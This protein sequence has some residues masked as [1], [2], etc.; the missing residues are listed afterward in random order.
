M[1]SSLVVVKDNK[2]IQ[3]SYKLTLVEQRIILSAI[4]K[5]D[6][7]K[8]LNESQGFTIS[9]SEIHDLFMESKSSAYSEIKK[10]VNRLYRRSI[11][12]DGEGSERRWIYE[13]QYHENKASVTLF[14]SP[15]IIPY[16]TQLKDSFTK[17]KLEYI[18]EFRSSYSIRIYELLVQ[19]TSKGEREIQIEDLKRILDVSDK[20]SR[21]ANFIARV[22][23][24]AIEDINQSS[25]LHVSF[26]T[27]KSG[28]LI[29]HIQFLFGIK[30]EV[31][32]KK[33]IAPIKSTKLTMEQFVRDN[34]KKT[35]G[36]SRDEVIKMMNNKH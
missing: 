1:N 5:I 9:V 14:F 29:T 22:I 13:K 30:A 24:P 35:L 26:G 7:T 33:R 11:I 16:L 15:T 36:K 21:P 18:S 12:L 34:P 25:N 28:R 8:A 10:A 19:W 3:A 23:Q 31:D 4:A 6:S 20:Y 32:Q 27:R 2:I 17:Y